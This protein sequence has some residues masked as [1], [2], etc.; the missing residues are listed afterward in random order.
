MMNNDNTIEEAKH[1]LRANWEKGCKCPTCGQMVKL[2]KRKLHTVMA[3]MLVKLYKLDHQKAGY[4]HAKDFVITKTGTNDFS[5]LRY[6]G[7]IVSKDNDDTKKRASGIWAITDKGR[8]FVRGEISV[9]EKV[10]IFDSKYFGYDGD[11]IKID[12][13]IG[14]EFDYGELMT[15][16]LPGG[17][18]QGA[19]L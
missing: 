17:V 5:K 2:Y 7:L 18:E 1:Y 19:L 16:Y 14:A 11:Q 9:P 13:A 15:G 10:L 8:Q 4:Y 6:W 3:L 12:R